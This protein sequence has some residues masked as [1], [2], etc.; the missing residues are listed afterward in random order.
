[1]GSKVWPHI[2][3][4]KGHNFLFDFTPKELIHWNNNNLNDLTTALP[5]TLDGVVKNGWCALYIEL[6]WRDELNILS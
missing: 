1:M 2:C 4:L 5:Y 3:E 6:L